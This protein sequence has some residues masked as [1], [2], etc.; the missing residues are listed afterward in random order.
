MVLMVRWAVIDR[1]NFPER[2][3]GSYSRH[4]EAGRRKQLQFLLGGSL[5]RSSSKKLK[6]KLSLFSAGL[7][8]VSGAFSTA[9]RLPSGCKSKL[10]SA[11][12]L[13]NW[14]GDQSCGLSA[15]KES[16]EVV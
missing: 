9:K 8:S 2:L 5:R 16:A 6:M 10:N 7:R 1:L 15:W 4:S 11:L 14:P 3:I 13:V 12:W